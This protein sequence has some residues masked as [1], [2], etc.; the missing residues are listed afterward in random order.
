VANLLRNRVAERMQEHAIARLSERGLQAEIGLQTWSSPGQ[1]AAI[2]LT[3]EFD[4]V[5][6]DEGP[7]LT[8]T[9]VGIG[10]RGKRAEAVADEAVEELLAHLEG[11]GA[12][13]I[14][15]ADQLMLPLALAEGPSSYTVNHATEHVRT[16]ARTI[17]A[18]LDRPIRIDEDGVT[19]CVTIGERATR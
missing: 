12:V 19:A 15:S 8:A 1:G 2:A 4:V 13:D 3:A 18:F 17:A 16:N 9:F 11:R 14:H 7:R 6:Q 5:N 10:A